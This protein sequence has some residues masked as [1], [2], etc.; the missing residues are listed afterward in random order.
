MG[1]FDV[2]NEETAPLDVNKR[3][4]G[5][6]SRNTFLRENISW[7]SKAMNALQVKLDCREGNEGDDFWN[8]SD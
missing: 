7:T 6:V 3:G 5:F 4:K 2:K 1:R 8:V